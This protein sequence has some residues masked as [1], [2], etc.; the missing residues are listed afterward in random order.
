MRLKTS[1]MRL[2]HF[3][4]S[5]LFLLFFRG[6]LLSAQKTFSAGDQHLLDS[7][8]RVLTVA[9]HDSTRVSA[10]IHMANI[11]LIQDMDKSMELTKQAEVLSKKINMKDGLASCYAMYG[12]DYSRK[13]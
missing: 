3:F 1:L 4:T 11:Y 12:Y 10:L 8:N 6:N 9:K 2:P 13:G 7:L 5:L